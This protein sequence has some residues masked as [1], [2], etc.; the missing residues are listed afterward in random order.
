M[1]SRKLDKL[2]S[3]VVRNIFNRD[4]VV[5][6]SEYVDWVIKD[7]CFRIQKELT[8]AKKMSIG[9]TYAHFFLRNKVLHF[10]SVSTITRKGKM[11][12]I[13]PSNNVI[14]TWFHVEPDDERVQHIP[15][16]N[17]IVSAVHVAC[18]ATK[19]DL[20]AHG[21]DAEK[22]IVIPLGIDLNAFVPG[23]AEKKAT[24]RKKLNISQDAV[25]VG[26]FQ[27][28]GDGW[29][30][31]MVPKKVKG[32]DVFC[33]TVA[34]LAKEKPIHVLLTGPARGYVKRR[35]DDAGIPYTHT[36]LKEY[37]DVVD[38]FHALDMYIIAS[39]VEGGPKAI[40]EAWACGVPLISTRMGMPADILEHKKNGLLVNVEDVDALVDSATLLIQNQ[41]LRDQVVSQGL[42]DVQQYG[43]PA[44]AK[45][46][47]E[48]LYR[49][50]L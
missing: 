18:E 14:L 25:V 23:D 5:F 31:G 2:W 49:P 17:K 9:L 26:S 35:L 47:A 42:A 45:Q 6:V 29:G 50:F 22:I 43:W 20:I 13:H 1:L 24:M 11:L 39:R 44:I 34:R 8:E 28:D 48:K 32:P 7:I 16:L 15:K 46:Y 27:K 33:D 12:R 40:L 10:G 3:I 41:E 4:D 30:E 38:Y 37:L 21:F 36:Y 19:R